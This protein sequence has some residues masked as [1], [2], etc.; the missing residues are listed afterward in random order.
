MSLSVRTRGRP[1]FARRLVHWWRNRM[2]R[3]RTM[4]DLDGCDPA[5]VA[6]I[7]RE[8]G[9]SG[10]ELCVLASKWPDWSDP[11]SRRMSA[12]RPNAPQT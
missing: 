7:A 9:V 12:D 8:V 10:A 3:R 2:S 1:D 6:R 11:L 5:D 4:A